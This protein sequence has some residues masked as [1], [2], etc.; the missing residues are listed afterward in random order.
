MTATLHALIKINQVC[1]S[2]TY[3]LRLNTNKLEETNFIHYQY[4]IMRTDTNGAKLRF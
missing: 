3:Y 4:H 1:F 2:L